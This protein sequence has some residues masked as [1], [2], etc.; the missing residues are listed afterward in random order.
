T[1][2]MSIDGNTERPE[3]G[4][5]WLRALARILDW[6]VYWAVRL[7]VVIAVGFAA[8]LY[9]SITGEYAAQ[10]MASIAKVSWISWIASPI[11][12]LCYHTVAEG[13]GG[14]TLGKRVVGLQ[15]SDVSLKP[16]TLKQGFKRSLA[17]FYDGLFFG[18]VAEGY[19]KDSP[20][21]QRSG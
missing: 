16:C 19:M 4:G 20:L 14:A 3:A 7:I 17:F 15:V 21:K 6:I 9:R 13:F 10:L 1:A 2:R 18:L 12:T 11:A 5:F 8:G